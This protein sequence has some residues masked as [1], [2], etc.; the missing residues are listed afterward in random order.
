MD[1]LD[2]FIYH[3]MVQTTIYYNTSY[4]YFW[5][6]FLWFQ[7][8]LYEK[9]C[10]TCKYFHPSDHLNQIFIPEVL[11]FFKLLFYYWVIFC[12]F[13]VCYKFLSSK[14]ILIYACDICSKSLKLNNQ[15][16]LQCL[17]QLSN[18]PKIVDIIS[19]LLGV[20]A[21]DDLVISYQGMFIQFYI[22]VY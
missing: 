19:Y 18:K 13:Y 17:K 3:Y 6:I 21:R 9:L 8:K 1:R 15:T 11:I 12:K 10:V 14:G 2:I 16:F 22:L 5:K 7:L 20:K 4:I